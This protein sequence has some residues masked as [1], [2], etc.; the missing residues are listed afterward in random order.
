MD[1]HK[2]L[3]EEGLPS[4]PALNYDIT[5]HVA[6]DVL[7]T[8]PHKRIEGLAHLQNFEYTMLC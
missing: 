6:A 7:A 1:L 8:Y 2:R 3:E 4:L 5:K